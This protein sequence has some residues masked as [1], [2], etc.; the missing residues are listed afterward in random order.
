LVPSLG[1]TGPVASG[2][3]V[4][5]DLIVAGLSTIAPASAESRGANDVI[6]LSIAP[7]ETAAA[8]WV[9]TCVLTA[10]SFAGSSA[11]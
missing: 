9:L 11:N 4:A 6:A 8:N 2:L 3:E 7:D 1:G 10:V 5:I